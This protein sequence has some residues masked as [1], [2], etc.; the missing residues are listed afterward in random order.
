MYLNRDLPFDL[1]ISDGYRPNP[2]H[3]GYLASL[4]REWFI[5]LDLRPLD[6][7]YWTSPLAKEIAEYTVV[8]GWVGSWLRYLHWYCTVALDPGVKLE[9]FFS[10]P[11]V[12]RKWWRSEEDPDLVT[13]GS[14]I[15]LQRS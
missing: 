15:R 10:A 1:F 13:S 11:T 9:D 2:Y 14:S 4:C 6:P 8:E 7:S 5:P 12:E 3:Y